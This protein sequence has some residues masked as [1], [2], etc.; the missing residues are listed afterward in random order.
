MEPHKTKTCAQQGN[1]SLE[2]HTTECERNIFRSLSDKN[3]YPE[4]VK[5]FLKK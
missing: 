2:R 4:D 1:S 5:K 3:S